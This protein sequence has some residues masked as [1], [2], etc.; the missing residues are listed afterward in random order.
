MTRTTTPP[1]SPA[2]P[3]RE[4]RAPGVGLALLALLA[5]APSTLAQGGPPRAVSVRL[6]EVVSREV[7]PTLRLPATL[8]PIRQAKVASAGE[9]LV[10]VRKVF[11]GVAYAK[12]AVLL[13]LDA[14]KETAA[15][16]RAKAAADA[17]WQRYK[18]LEAG[19]RAEDVEVAR[20]QLARAIASRQEADRERTRIEDLQTR[21]A[22]TP[23]QKDAAVRA[24][25]VARAEVA[26]A[27]SRLDALL[28]GAREERVSAAQ[29]DW[30]AADAARRQ[31][32]A[33]LDEMTLKAPFAGRAAQ[34]FV[35]V[36][37]WVSKGGQVVDLVDASTIDAVVLVPQDRLAAVP[38]GAEATVILDHLD[39]PRR[40]TAKVASIGP[41]AQAGSRAIPVVLRFPNPDGVAVPMTSAVADVPVGEPVATTL[42]PKDALVRSGSGP[43][44]AFVDDAG[45]AGIRMV[46]V[47]REV[48]GF[49]EVLEGLEPGDQVV[50]H[51][52]EQLQPGALLAPDGGGA[53][54]SPD[55]GEGET[56]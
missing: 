26:A 19:E 6:G 7:R 5:A 51:G 23:S 14:A 46:K 35:E 48:E 28:A 12:D 1:R 32:Q 4:A 37:D 3:R 49:V 13:E 30:R 42:A 29:A 43:P 53:A 21:G 24:A 25:D 16:D 56:P 38:L 22:A 55:P 18:E 31:A 17:A 44:R 9:G 39:P 15:R 8:L 10:K 50:T 11:F 52:N 36:G 34:V 45:R 47:G 2:R 41:L 54:S 40:F 27:R 20:A 33:V